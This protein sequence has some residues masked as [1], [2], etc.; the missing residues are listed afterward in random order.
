MVEDDDEVD[1]A[2]LAA[3][4]GMGWEYVA[5]T[6]AS[7]SERIGFTPSTISH[8][9]RNSAYSAF[10]RPVR[11]RRNLTVITRT[12]AGHLESVAICPPGE[13]ECARRRRT[14]RGSAC[15]CGYES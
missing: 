9:V 2:I 4:Q 15:R 8:G 1:Q 11:G 6:N 5:D 14:R 10:V 3:A 13:Q 12:R 7:D